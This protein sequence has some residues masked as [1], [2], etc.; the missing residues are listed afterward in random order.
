MALAIRATVV[1]L[2]I[3][4][5]SAC[6]ES[7]AFQTYSENG[8]SVKLPESWKL[9]D[10]SDV[11]ITADREITFQTGE[12]SFVGFYVYVRP[13]KD[14]TLDDFSQRFLHVAFPA[15]SD[16]AVTQHKNKKIERGRHRGISAQVETT[17]VEKDK[18]VVE[19]FPL[20]FEKA[21]VFAVFFSEE[22]VAKEVAKAA[23]K[24]LAQLKV[25]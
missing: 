20:K 4:C 14:V 9:I 1:V 10:D 18:T 5:A 13:E 7:A 21:K 16:P 19:I 11:P 8:F 17:L 24:V 25:E 23:E 6:S 15:F 3:L 12:F 22:A 2:L